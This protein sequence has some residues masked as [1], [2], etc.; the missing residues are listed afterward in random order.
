VRVREDKPARN[1]RPQVVATCFN[2]PPEQTSDQ[3]ARAL[4][5]LSGDEDRLTLSLDGHKLRLTS[6]NKELWPAWAERRPLTK[7]DLARY[8]LQIAPFVLRHLRDRPVTMTRYPDGI[9]GGRFY[10]KS[11]KAS[12]P[13]F[14]RRF[15]SFSEHQEGDDEY[16][17]CNDAATLMWLAQLA[18]LELHVA[19][20]RIVAEPDAPH[21]STQFGGGLEQ[22]EHSTL[23]YPDFL[24]TDID[25]YIYSG[26][27]PRGAE[28]ELNREGFQRAI[29]VARWYREMLEGIGL[30][31]FLKT[32]GKTGLHLYVP[33]ARTLDY[34]SVRAVAETLAR[35]VWQAHPAAT[36]LEWA[37]EARLGKVFLDYNMNRRS[38]SLA[39]PYSPRAVDW[40]G[41]STPLRWDELEDAYP[42]QFDVLSV[43]G[44]LADLGDLWAHSLESRVDLAQLLTS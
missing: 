2:P 15:V 17:V 33:I 43:P 21:L 3:I 37:V 38:A 34:D 18:D 13:P 20:T 26:H 39:A 8:Y 19:H 25:P 42:T 40:A 11:P 32:T 27:E 28:P 12:A 5:A 16:F 35:R 22:V 9:H 44:R 7:R 14:V 24:V 10:Q 30:H 23:N 41:V 36:T 29:D 31:P 4:E 6:L 1:V